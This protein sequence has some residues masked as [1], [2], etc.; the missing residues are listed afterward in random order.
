MTNS[1]ILISAMLYMSS[2]LFSGSLLAQTY[3]RNGMVVSDQRLASEIGIKVLQQG[4]NAVDASVATA[5]AL[6]VTHPQA[7]NIGGGGFLVFMDSTGEATTIDFREKAP[8]AASRD[9]Y[10][11]EQGNLPSGLNA[12]GGT[13]GIHHTGLKSVGVPGTVAGLFLAHQKYGVLPWQQLVQP[14]IEIASEGT[15][16]PW[17]IYQHARYFREHSPEEFMQNFFNDEDGNPTNFWC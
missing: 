17:D 6:A 2:F 5:F 12:W 1:E 8:L 10:L 13:T 14:A 9:M 4:G 3:G 15:P 7:G 16:M 11:D